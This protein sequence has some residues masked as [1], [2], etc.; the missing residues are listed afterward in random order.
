MEKGFEIKLS[1]DDINQIERCKPHFRGMSD[2]E[3]VVFYFDRQNDE[4]P[5][6]LKL[7]RL[8]A[9]KAILRERFG[10]TPIKYKG[11]KLEL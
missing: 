4:L 5:A 3:L 11:K 2:K 6:D 9:L 7:Y 10:D 1:I 8:F